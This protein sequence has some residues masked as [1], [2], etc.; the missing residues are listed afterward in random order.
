MKLRQLLLPLLILLSLG[1]GAQDTNYARQVLGRL[2]SDAFHGRGYSFKGDSIAAR[3]IRN[4]LRRMGVKPLEGTD[5]Y[6]QRYTFPTSAMEGPLS[7]TIGGK[8]L[9]AY[10][11]F[12]VAPFSKSTWGDYRVITLTPTEFLDEAKLAKFLAKNQKKLSD[13]FVYIDATDTEGFTEEGLKRLGQSLNQ[14]RQQN[15][16][17]SRG[18]LLGM[19]Q[20][21]TCSPAYTSYE[22]G[23]AYI[24]TLAE[25]MP[26]KV[27]ELNCTLFTQ[28]YDAYPTQ[29]V[30]GY[31]EGEVD[32]LV[33][34]T[35]HYDH[36]GT[37]GDSVV[38]YGAHDNGIGTTAVLDLA[39]MAAHDKPHYTQVFCFFSGEEAGLRGSKYMAD[40]PLF[41]FDKVR[42]LINIDLFCGGDEGLM[43]F[44]GNDPDTAPFMERM[45]NLNKALG[46]A[47]EIRRRNNSA[48]SD[49]YHFSKQMPAIYILTLGQR[50]GGYH[51]PHDTCEACGLEHYINYITLISA[52]AL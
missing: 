36:I 2:T 1:A 47:P 19:K 16:F 50:Y 21:N 13:S 41:D 27:K 15:P 30:C 26:S 5:D 37:M 18:I 22:H 31:V 6:Y 40:H 14:L 46:I 42:I 38:F 29:N 39:R 35:A 45:E 48:N 4:E 12:R 8:K 24:E 20:M 33:V 32:T 25:L 3:F 51:D 34:F 17:G 49:H 52:L 9:K 43:V 11:E 7:L 44:N 10:E 23:Y 28:F